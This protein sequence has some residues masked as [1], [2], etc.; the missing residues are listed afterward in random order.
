VPPRPLYSIPAAV[1]IVALVTIVI[2]VLYPPEEYGVVAALAI[3]GVI[4]LVIMP[5]VLCSGLEWKSHKV[6][7]VTGLILVTIGTIAILNH[8]GGSNRGYV[9]TVLMGMAWGLIERLARHSGDC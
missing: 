3:F 9:I 5:G 2:C 4:L 1:I 7:R 8:M 6:R